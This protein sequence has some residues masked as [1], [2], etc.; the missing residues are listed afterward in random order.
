MRDVY[1]DTQMGGLMVDQMGLLAAMLADSR[2][3]YLDT[4]MV[5]LMD[6]QMDLKAAM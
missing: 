5:G 4:R 1:L 3:V 2:G 6:G